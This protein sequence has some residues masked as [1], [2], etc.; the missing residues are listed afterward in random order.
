MYKLDLLKL[1][2]VAYILISIA[3]A[4]ELYATFVRPSD[5]DGIIRRSDAAY[6]AAVFDSPDARGQGILQQIFRQNELDRDLVKAT[7]AACSR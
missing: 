2:P 3:I 5:A 4:L 6:K 1:D 7:L